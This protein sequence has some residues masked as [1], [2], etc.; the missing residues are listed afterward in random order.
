MSLATPRRSRTVR[1]TCQSCRERKARYSYRGIVRADRDH[2]LC[3]ECF[4][5]ERE[6]QRAKGL[7]E[8]VP[9]AP[10]SPF[11]ILQTRRA[12]TPHQIEHR[13][14]VLAHLQRC[15]ARVGESVL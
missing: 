1:H 14:R 11:G 2:T 12:M 9:A 7:V 15:S 8:R 10:R 6:R 4:R 3:F 13:V 5:R